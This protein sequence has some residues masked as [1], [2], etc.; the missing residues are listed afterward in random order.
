MTEKVALI[1]DIH[2]NY[3]ALLEVGSELA[4]DYPVA[5]AGDLLDYGPEPEACADYLLFGMNILR[6]GEGNPIGTFGNHDIAIRDANYSRFRTEHGRKSAEWNRA[7]A[8]KSDI[9]KTFLNQE[10]CNRYGEMM[11]CHG[12]DN[13]PWYNLFSTDIQKMDEMIER[14]PS[15]EIFVVAHSHLQFKVNYNN[16]LFVNPGSVGQSR[17]GVSLAHYSILDLDTKEVDF[18]AVEYNIKSVAD[19]IVDNPC[20]DNFLATRLYLGI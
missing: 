19:R 20:L 7:V 11:I 4:G 6:N 12:S 14:N 5:F 10:Y 16:R 8:E 3:S 18:K 15:V 9:I 13:D 17:N 1:A 2:G